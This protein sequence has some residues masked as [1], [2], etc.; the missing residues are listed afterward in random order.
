MYRSRCTGI[1]FGN[2]LRYGAIQSGKRVSGEYVRD[3]DS[4]I[5][6]PETRPD[7][8]RWVLGTVPTWEHESS[9][10]LRRRRF[11]S[12]PPSFSKLSLSITALQLAKLANQWILPLGEDDTSPNS[13]I[14][15]TVGV[16]VSRPRVPYRSHRTQIYGFASPLY[17]NR[18]KDVYPNRSLFLPASDSRTPFPSPVPVVPETW[19]LC[20]YHDDTGFLNENVNFVGTKEYV[21]LGTADTPAAVAT[22][23]ASKVPRKHE[24]P[25]E[26]LVSSCAVLDVR[27]R[28]VGLL[29]SGKTVPRMAHPVEAQEKRSV[30]GRHH[31]HDAPTVGTGMHG[32]GRMD[33]AMH[34]RLT[35]KRTRRRI[36]WILATLMR[37]P[38]VPDREAFEYAACV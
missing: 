23:R 12:P 19:Q 15:H 35:S 1:G 33:A 26:D 36:F 30:T 6:R 14:S 32:S 13:S 10:L 8:A 17:K 2:G 34:A 31:F 38:T 9:Q 3:L 37:T 18:S 28:F 27:S 22:E 20:S 16:R 4:P 7:S 29:W 5:P 25:F 11:F 21:W 24:R